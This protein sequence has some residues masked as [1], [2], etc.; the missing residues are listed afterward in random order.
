MRHFCAV[1]HGFSRFWIA[2]SIWATVIV[3][4]VLP[5]GLYAQNGTA[6][7]ITNERVTVETSTS[8]C[9]VPAAINSLLT[10]D[11]I[12]YLY[13]EA[14]LTPSD[15]LTSDWLAP[16]GSV[17][18]GG[19]WTHKAGAFCFTGVSL[20]ITDTPKNRLGKWQARV[21]DNSAQVVVVPFTVMFPSDTAVPTISSQ[22]G[23][24]NGASFQAGISPGSWGTIVGTNLSEN[25]R[26]WELADFVDGNSLPTSLDGVSVI[27]DSLPA[28]VE[29]ISSTQINFLV[30][31]DN[32]T[33]SVAVQVV[34]NG[35]PSNTVTAQL[36]SVSPAFFEWKDPK[37]STLYAAA[38]HADYSL[39]GNVNLFANA[40][41]ANPGETVILWGTGFGQTNPP[42]VIGQLTIGAPAVAGNLMVTVGGVPARIIAAALSPGFAGLYQIAIQI[43]SSASSGD[44]PVVAEMD[45]L[46]SPANVFLTVGG[47]VPSGPLA[48]TAV[49]DSAPLPFMLLTIN[50]SGLDS[51][52]P[53]NVSFS[54]GN[55]FSIT[56]P[57]VNVNS[58]GSFKVAAPLLVD[59]KT[60]LIS[61]GS[62]SMT[63]AQDSVTSEPVMLSIQDL[64]P[65]SAYG[66][67][68]GDISHAMLI[69]D[70]LLLGYRINQL[71]TFQ[72]LPG[73]VVDTTQA[74]ATL[75]K[76]LY[77]VLQA[78]SDVDMVATNNA[79]VIPNGTQANGAPIQFDQ[80]SLDIMDRVNA[81]F[82]TQTFASLPP[83]SGLM[84][85]FAQILSRFERAS[86]GGRIC[87]QSQDDRVFKS[88]LSWSSASTKPVRRE[89]LMP[90]GLAAFSN[91][92]DVSIIG[93]RSSASSKRPSRATRAR[94]DSSASG[95]KQVLDDMETVNGAHDLIEG[96]QSSREASNWLTL[97]QANAQVAQGT[98][99]L[100]SSSGA[101]NESGERAAR[102]LGC[103][104]ALLQDI[105]V[106]GNVAGQLLAFT[107]G[108]ATGNKFLV[109]AAVEAMDANQGPALKAGVD[110]SLALMGGP[111]AAAGFQDVSTT[112]SFAKTLWELGGDTLTSANEM[113][114]Q[115]ASEAQTIP[116]FDEDIGSMIGTVD[117]T[118]PN[119]LLVAQLGVA[120]SDNNRQ[121]GTTVTDSIGGYE[122]MIPLFI[123]GF[124]YGN[125]SLQVYD[126]AS[127]YLNDDF[128]V[129]GSET[130]DLSG[131]T[132]SEPLQV[133]DISIACDFSAANRCSD[134]CD[135]LIGDGDVN[136]WENCIG[137][138]LGAYPCAFLP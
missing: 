45:G 18:K 61:A 57:A 31:S 13:F 92:R 32:K 136:I 83:S 17:I 98:A 69:F 75:K 59:P 89:E 41:P 120:L 28:Y 125:A 22:N 19:S 6:I 111:S 80:T 81:L 51:N 129:L 102:E 127:Y 36:E 95:L 88:T 44:Q 91:L 85:S 96:M 77:A 68:L 4:G 100:L 46:K 7:T 70:S 26:Q 60:G 11:N 105:D 130:V 119:N 40:S 138:C 58:D 99:S 53:V 108:A 76:L 106:V 24:D 20:M 116:H 124:G 79:T 104:G 135:L 128:T 30:P 87:L 67:S 82:L 72:A 14:N 29:Y 131:A 47:S 94:P 134:E 84:S 27:V 16:D 52:A 3:A 62:V 25:T 49:S 56:T 50:T 65:L 112:A 121:M 71:Q 48:I 21:Y 118:N 10:T 97:V 5:T 12:V 109:D 33:G 54:D 122:M 42:T 43:P 38:T 114:A 132:A 63:I 64:P 2:V 37:T 137:Q 115:L 15:N 93:V 110:L 35:V 74:Q 133:P 8:T 107:A 126:P 101:L 23:V 117:V 39:V 78:R 55:D 66:T 1:W 9:R 73:N 90:P 34:N 123:E 113:P 103:V 86:H